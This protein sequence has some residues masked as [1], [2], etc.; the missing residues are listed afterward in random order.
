MCTITADS[1]ERATRYTGSHVMLSCVADI[2]S[3]HSTPYY[4]SNLV[5]DNE[6]WMSFSLQIAGTGMWGFSRQ[7][8]K[9]PKYN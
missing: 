4:F 7:K 1:S 5:I 6:P 8:E 3:L 9:K 2:L